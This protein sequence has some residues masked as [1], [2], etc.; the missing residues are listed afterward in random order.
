MRRGVQALGLRPLGLR[1]CWAVLL[2]AFCWSGRKSH[3]AQVLSEEDARLLRLL[4]P[5]PR[6]ESAWLDVHEKLAEEVAAA[7]R[8]DGF[9]YML[10]GDSIMEAFR[11]QSVGWDASDRYSG[12]LEAWRR[13]APPKS[14]VAGI[15]GDQAVHLLW[16]L[17]NG[18]G[19]RGLNPKSVSV[20]IGTN[21]VAHLS[22]MHG[23]NA[24]RIGH[25]VAMGAQQCVRELQRQA[26]QATVVV[27]A[28]LPMEPLM[29]HAPQSMFGP[30]VEAA[31]AELKQY[32]AAQ[33]SERLKFK[34]CGGAFKQPAGGVN[35]ELMEDGVHPRGRGAEVLLQCILGALRS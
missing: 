22:S 12:N 15:A 30:M 25:I 2:L 32:V 8:A 35:F 14:H 16:R 34:D 7:Q 23:Y 18:E 31:N 19:P 21:D 28:L 5:A 20:M 11:A 10:Y 3:A 26:P 9:D 24:S 1:A 29:L 33:G 17:Q 6:P 13:L 4:E 27:L